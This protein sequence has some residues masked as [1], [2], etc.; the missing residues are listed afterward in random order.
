[1]T[2]VVVDGARY[3]VRMSGTGPAA[4]LLHGFSGRAVDWSPLAARLRRSMTTIAVDLLGH[5][6]S[7]SPTD[8]ARHAVER[9]AADLV[10]ILRR[11]GAEPA[12]IVGYSFGARVA[13]RI[14]VDEPAVVRALV[15]ESP[16]AGI[17]DPQARARRREADDDLAGR[18]ERDGIE[19]F[20]DTWWEA[21]P[22]FASERTLPAATRARLRAQRLRNRPEALARSLRGAGQGAMAPLHGRLAEITAP[23]LVVAG[24]L[25]PIGAVRAGAI[26]T[27]IPGARL[28]LLEGAGHAAHRESPGRFRRL[29]LDFLEEVPAA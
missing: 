23:T 28:A 22:V 10:A 9:Q 16:S 5:G 2:R 20:V 7:D 24:A 25:D 12:A 29:V 21:T 3:E 1:V 4:L 6:R 26:A 27:A 17:A 18:I 19:S 14:A 13:L 15:L 8:P 11:Q